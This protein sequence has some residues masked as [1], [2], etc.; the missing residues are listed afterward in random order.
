[1]SASNGSR[2]CRDTDV[3]RL[4][5]LGRK[6]PGR[7]W[8]AVKCPLCV[9]NRAR[10]SSDPTVSGSPEGRAI[11]SHDRSQHGKQYSRNQRTAEP[12]DS[13]TS[14]GSVQPSVGNPFRLRHA[15]GKHTR[16]RLNPVERNGTIRIDAKLRCRKVVRQSQK[17][18]LGVD[19]GLRIHGFLLLVRGNRR[20]GSPKCRKRERLLPEQR[21]GTLP[22]AHDSRRHLAYLAG[23]RRDGARRPCVSS[24][25]GVPEVESAY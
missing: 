7:T 16:T 24:Q 4:F 17:K 2:P 1:M 9:R 21:F 20:N 11:I 23:F 19:K 8:R 13:V 14:V 12:V 18:L 22:I 15:Y 5:R 25:R 6:A 10:S 3:S